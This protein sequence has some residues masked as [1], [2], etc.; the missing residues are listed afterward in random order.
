[1]PDKT[2]LSIRQRF[3][4]AV[5]ITLAFF[6][7]HLR[8]DEALAN[9]LATLVSE[10]AKLEMEMDAFSEGSIPSAK[11]QA[12][13]AWYA[14][15]GGQL[16]DL[17]RQLKELAAKVRPPELPIIEEVHLPRD[18]TTEVEKFLVQQA[19]LQNERTRVE[20]DLRDAAPESRQQALEAWEASVEDRRAAQRELATQIAR[21]QPIFAPPDPLGFPTAIDAR[22]REVLLQQLSLSNERAGFATRIQLLP[23]EEQDAELRRWDEKNSLRAAELRD[24]LIQIN[25][26]T[27]RP[28]P[29]KL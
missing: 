21:Q 8:A 10:Q 6:S 17:R 11:A 26:E 27:H 1:M 5:A 25:E 15:N 14:K 9:A 2:L 22:L 18:A 3:G 4:F 23:P 7:H 13:E 29:D 19:E 28:I 12:A 20:N 16:E 24:R